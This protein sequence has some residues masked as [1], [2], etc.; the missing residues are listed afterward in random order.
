MSNLM[1]DK[2]KHIDRSRKDLQSVLET[3]G[4]DL[5]NSNKSLDSL[6]ANVGQLSLHNDVNPDTWE[7]V[8]EK[9]DPGTYWK[10][11]EDWGNI[12]DIDA[13]MEADTQ[14]YTGKIFYLVRCSDNTVLHDATNGYTNKAIIGLQAFRFSDQNPDDQLATTTAHTWDSTKDIIAPNGEHFRWIIGYT[15]STTAITL[16]QSR[17]FRPEAV[18][19]WSGTFRGICFEDA[20]PS[21]STTD[22]Q[23]HYYNGTKY[24]VLSS[25]SI[26]NHDANALRCEA[27]RYF[28]VKEPVV[29]QFITGDLDTRYAGSAFNNRTKTVIID[30][31]CVV[32]FVKSHMHVCTYFRSTKPGYEKAL[33]ISGASIDEVSNVYYYVNVSGCK[34]KVWAYVNNGYVR[35]YGN[36]PRT[37]WCY[38]GAINNSNILCDDIGGINNDG[39]ANATNTN[40]ECKRILGTVNDG[41]FRY[42]RG[43]IKFD[44]I[45]GGIGKYAFRDCSRMPTE[46]ICIRP[47]DYT[48]TNSI[49]HGAFMGT[50]VEKIDLRDSAITSMAGGV[51]ADYSTNDVSF[52]TG[53]FTGMDRLKILH[54]PK[55][56]TTIPSYLCH[57]IS[58]LTTVT[59]PENLTSIGSYA[60]AECDSLESIIIPETVQ[61][62]GEYA[63][64]GCNNLLTAEV[65]SATMTTVPTRLFNGCTSLQKVVLPPKT[66]TLNEGIF[67]GCASLERVILP[68]TVNY[69]GN[70]CFEYC[71]R[72]KSIQYENPDIGTMTNMG[73]YC[74]QGCRSLTELFKLDGLLGY[75]STSIKYVFFMECSSM[76]FTVL[77]KKPTNANDSN[78]R[79]NFYKNTNAK[80]LVPEDYAYTGQLFLGGANWNIRNF[81]DFIQSIPDRTGGTATNFS[82]GNDFKYTYF[83]QSNTS[84]T[85]SFTVYSIYKNYYV[86]EIDGV[87]EYSTTQKDD[88]W[89]L[90]SDYVTAKN[91]TLA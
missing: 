36:M 3:K 9:E 23:Y 7:G 27:P 80:I 17:Y 86:K 66:I 74:L 53:P 26:T 42:F 30:G 16:W 14:E 33:H 52:S 81:L 20:A 32:E 4:V 77:P 65:N 79:S 68:N 47:D 54:F 37:A 70:Y 34:G 63:F 50:P 69:I 67:S 1:I 89:I 49:Q 90:V 38:F 75:S 56:M 55:S 61:T 88:T 2:L 25:F 58:T 51:S 13:I 43:H 29:T 41:A 31:T 57:R 82:L 11:D 39:V 76:T 46:I 60:F 64:S 6:I 62:I 91:C 45:G 83:L 5:T 12:I 78:Y 59:L 8:M 24:E 21:G 72:V 15:N 40:F 10:G 85:A 48:G 35:L 87:L 19:Y 28:E 84:S 44:S 18:V 22:T 73:D 71:E